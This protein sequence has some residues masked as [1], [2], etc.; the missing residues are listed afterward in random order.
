MTDV[1]TANGYKIAVDAKRNVVLI[2]VKNG[3]PKTLLLDRS[4]AVELLGNLEE[5]IE[6]AFEFR[7]ETEK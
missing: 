3:I 4:Q 2:E 6:F 5:A 7:E 1:S